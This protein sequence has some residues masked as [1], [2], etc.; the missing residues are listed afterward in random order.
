VVEKID[1]DGDACIQFTSIGNKQWVNRTNFP[2][3]KQE[4]DG[5]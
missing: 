1:E 3:M 5:Y 2:D 4:I